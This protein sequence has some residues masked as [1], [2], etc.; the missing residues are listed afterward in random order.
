MSWSKQC[1]EEV[2]DFCLGKML[3]QR[4]NKGDFL[5]Y[6]ANVN[7]R[8]GEF[9]LDNLRQMRFEQH[10][11][12]RYGLKYGD[13][14][15][16]EG[17]EPGRCAIWKEQKPG[18]M[19]QKALHR[20]RPNE[21]L[22]YRFLYYSFLHMG[23]SGG[24]APLFT[25]ATIKHLPRQNLAKV[26]IKFPSIPLQER[27]ANILSSYD[28]LIENNRRRI[29]LLE[30]SAR[31]LYKEWFVHLRFPGHEHVQIVDGVPDGWEPLDL[32]SIISI[33]HGFAFKG[34]FFMEEPTSR[35]LLTPGNFKVG[36]G[37]KIEKLKY[38]S[39]EAS[40]SEE[41]VLGKDDLLIT[42]TDLSKSSDTLGYPL[43]VP[44]LNDL[45]FLHNQRL[46]KVNPKEGMP[47]YRFFLCEMFKDFRYRSYV[48]GSASGTSVKH[49]SPKKILSYK[50]LSPPYNKSA[51]LKKF[52]EFVGDLNTQCQ[53]L[54]CTNLR[55]AEAR[56]LLLPRLMNGEITV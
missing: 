19:I 40:L 28:D 48:Q 36:G 7:V 55:L 38:Y 45:L 30:Q 41:F 29:Q 43:L 27:I 42:M 14:V 51:L 13:I 52:D 25:G 47:F 4:K 37:I 12:D 10:E 54:L 32:N 31:L 8:W 1:L 46:G 26:E 11:L 3:D 53:N 6:L 18:M 35:I 15:M 39:E 2:A 9:N 49:T 56:D 16:C 50:P 20:I 34:E 5:P 33:K 44:E 24:F 23:K 17:G 22:D 21:S